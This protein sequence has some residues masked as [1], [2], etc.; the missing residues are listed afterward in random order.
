MYRANLDGKQIVVTIGADSSIWT[1]KLGRGQVTL[2]NSDDSYL[3]ALAHIHPDDLP[4][5]RRKLKPNHANNY[6]SSQLA[7]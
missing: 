4:E 2:A 5:V 3:W 1:W 7:G 6:M